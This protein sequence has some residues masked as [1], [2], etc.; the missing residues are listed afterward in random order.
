MLWQYIAKYDKIILFA[1]NNDGIIDQVIIHFSVSDGIASSSNFTEWKKS[2]A[3]S[4]GL[5]AL[6]SKG[7]W[8]QMHCLDSQR[9]SLVEEK[10]GVERLKYLFVMKVVD[11]V[12]A[13][14][15]IQL[16]FLE[17]ELQHGVTMD[18]ADTFGGSW[19]SNMGLFLDFPV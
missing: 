15:M 11:T 4:K 8:G 9:S 10:S 5:R 18:T 1:V 7:K 17:H 6:I 12:I 13:P 16:G 19:S 3:E 14:N 2:Y